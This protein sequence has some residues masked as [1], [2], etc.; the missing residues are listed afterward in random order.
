MMGT[1]GQM[2][3]VRQVVITGMG[4]CCHLGDDLDAMSRLLRNGDTL[5]FVPYDV[6]VEYG[7]RCQIIGPYTGNV[8]DEALDITKKQSRFMGRASRIAL[9]AARL[10]LADAK[11]DPK[12]IGIVVG[13]GTGDVDTH[14]DVLRKLDATKQMRRVGPAVIPK[15]MS[16]TVT[17]NLVNVLK[18][19]GPSLSASAACAGGAYNIIIASQMIQLGVIEAA[20]VG[21]VEAVDPHFFA[22]FDAMRAFNSQDNENP[23]RASRP[24]AADR[25]GFIFGEGA[26]MLLLESRDAANRRGAQVLAIVDGYGMSS[27]GDGEMVAPNETGAVAAMAHALKNA[28]CPADSIGYINTHGTSTPL[29]DVSEIRAIRRAFGSHRP[30]YS[31][32]KG[33]TGHTITAAGAI[34]AIF[35][36]QMLRGGWIAPSVNASPLDPNLED[37]SPLQTPIDIDLHRAMSCSFGFGGT[38]AALI[39]SRDRA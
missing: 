39:L 5:P 21:G 23:V 6:A 11:I 19:T 35:T 12:R 30:F 4:A 1:G 37:Y 15:I 29:G 31:S 24:Y 26:G 34:E 8:S 33:Y 27:D 20:L 14:V 22:G 18:S 9:K 7:A 38:N 2:D 16:S 10:A 36:V 13:S 32:T 25:Q 3:H 28:N 17:A